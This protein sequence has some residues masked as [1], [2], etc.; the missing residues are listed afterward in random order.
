MYFMNIFFGGNKTFSAAICN[1]CTKFL[2]IIPGHPNSVKGN[3]FLFNPSTSK[4]H[5]HMKRNISH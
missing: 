1:K 3:K 5:I 2:S 4:T